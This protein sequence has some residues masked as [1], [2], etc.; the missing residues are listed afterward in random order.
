MFEKD[1]KNALNI[2]KK[3]YEDHPNVPCQLQIIDSDT[4]K[5]T[6]PITQEK[7]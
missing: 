5:P 6:W 1:L 4:L 3:F 7:G 2:V